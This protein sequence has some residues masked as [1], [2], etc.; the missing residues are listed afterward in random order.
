MKFIVLNISRSFCEGMHG[1][2]LYT[3][4]RYA[5]LVN[6]KAQPNLKYAVAVAGGIIREIYQLYRDENGPLWTRVIEKG[7]PRY[8]FHG[9]PIRF[10]YCC[11]QDID[12]K[13]IKDLISHIGRELTPKMKRRDFEY[14]EE[15]DSIPLKTMQ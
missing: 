4:T 10:C 14:Y 5:W 12:K 7:Q 2:E 11:N 8:Y 9:K 13:D 15:I 6:P 1:W 3:A